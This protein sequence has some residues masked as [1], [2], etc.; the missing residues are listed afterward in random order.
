[1]PVI[2]KS[3]AGEVQNDEHDYQ[4][5]DYAEEDLNALAEEGNSDFKQR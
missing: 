2:L 1:V 3:V 5:T 4:E